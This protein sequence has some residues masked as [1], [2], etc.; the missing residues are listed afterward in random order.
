MNLTSRVIQIQDLDE[1]FNFESRKLSEVIS[2]ENER[3]FHIWS[4]RWRRESLQ[5]Y[6]PM[7][8][9]FLIRSPD[10][11]SS[12]SDEGLLMGYMLAQPFLFLEGQTQ[13]LWVEHISYSSLK[14][15]D[16]LCELAYKLSR[17]KHFQ[18][19]LFPNNSGIMNSVAGLKPEIWQPS[20]ISIKTTK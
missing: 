6:L 13:C 16:E 3:M 9:C 14:A 7:G 4:S 18:R 19:V 12:E 15:R 2:D 20:V 11:E 5:H 8:W 10:I 17:D 1:I